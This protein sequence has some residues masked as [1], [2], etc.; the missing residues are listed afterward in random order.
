MRIFVGG[1]IAPDSMAENVAI[2]LEK[3]DLNIQKDV[4]RPWNEPI[5][6]RLAWL[7]DELSRKAFPNRLYPGEKNYIRA[8]QDYR[9]EVFF[10]TTASYSP[11]LLKRIRTS[12][13]IMALWW[14]DPIANSKRFELLDPCWDYIFLKDRA[15]VEKMR[16]AK[17][18][19]HYLPEAMNPLWHRPITG[20]VHDRIVIAGN[21][22]N[23]RQ[24]LIELL[25]EQNFQMELYGSTPPRWAKACVKKQW[26]GRYITKEEKSRC[27]GAGLASLNSFSF[28]E[29]DSGNCR[30][31]EIAGAGGLQLCEHRPTLHEFF[32][33]G[34]EILVYGSFEELLDQLQKA[35]RFPNEAN[36]IRKAAA[37]RAVSEHTYEHRLR[38]AFSIMGLA[39]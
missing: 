7:A 27:F 12:C 2:T 6:S 24:R 35:S 13:T 15:G 23:F 34:K 4:S 25:S 29:G 9:P 20:Q 26:A 36:R 17:I 33:P 11:E 32:E 38:E 30:L 10:S 31:F 18:N 37:L 22:Y 21:F 5:F 39:V 14:G 1:K 3:K 19:A 28:G 8:I 16:L